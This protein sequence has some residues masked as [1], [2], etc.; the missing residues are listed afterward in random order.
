MACRR[1]SGPSPC[2]LPPRRPPLPRPGRSP[3]LALLVEDVTALLDPARDQHV[4]V[5]AEGSPRGE[6][7]S[8]PRA[9]LRA[10]LRVRPCSRLRVRWVAATLQWPAAKLQANWIQEEPEDAGDWVAF[11]LTCGH[12][13]RYFP[14]RRGGSADRVPQCGGELRQRCPAATLLSSASPSSARSAARRC[15]AELFGTTI[16]AWTLII[17]CRMRA[18]GRF[19]RPEAAAA[20]SR[21]PRSGRGLAGTR[22]PVQLRDLREPDQGDDL[23]FRDLAVVELAE[24]PDHLV[25]PP[26][27]RVV[28]LDLPW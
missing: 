9:S 11:C 12:T 15:D 3:D 2:P 18:A 6:P 23:V 22:F 10:R 27:L 25:H 17:R 24:K 20:L 8:P 19:I 26:D 7:A 28:V 1:R 4:A 13:L 16:R 5:D 14:L 21:H